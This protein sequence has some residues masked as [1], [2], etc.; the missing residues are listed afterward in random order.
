MVK[1]SKIASSENS[2]RT[3]KYKANFFITLGE[4]KENIPT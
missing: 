1:K 3:K 2:Q 4:R